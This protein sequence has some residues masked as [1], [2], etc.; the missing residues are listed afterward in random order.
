MRIMQKSVRAAL[1]VSLIATGSLSSAAGVIKENEVRTLSAV[2]ADCVLGYKTRVGLARE[3]LIND[4]PSDTLNSGKYRRLI[5]GNCLVKVSRTQ[6]GIQMTFPGEL[7]RYA[8]AGALIRIDFAQ[9]QFDDFSKV[10]PLQH[11]PMPVLDEASLPKSK[12][13]ADQAKYE[14]E[15]ERVDGFLARYTE[16]V[17]R[18]NPVESRKLLASEVASAEEKQT[19]GSM[20]DGLSRCMPEGSTVRFGRETLR[21]AIAVAYYRLADAARKLSG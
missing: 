17:V 21:G 19:F 8:L 14:F 13:K 10:A 15:L 16:C 6:T 5:D 18:R 9:I 1:V 7:Y 11:R 2:Y 3:Y 20:N 12:K 4:L